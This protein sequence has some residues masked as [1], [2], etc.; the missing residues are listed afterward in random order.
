MKDR[1]G[2]GKPAPIIC[3]QDPKGHAC[4]GRRDRQAYGCRRAGISNEDDEAFPRASR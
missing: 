3:S 4:A 1:Q 2:G